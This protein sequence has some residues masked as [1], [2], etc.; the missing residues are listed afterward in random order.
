MIPFYWDFLLCCHYTKQRS[1][2]L[3]K[4]N[5][6]S[7]QFINIVVNLLDALKTSFSHRSLQARSV[8]RKDSMSDA[9]VAR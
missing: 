6:F 2:F 1:R 4:S 5:I 3:I 7:F 8:G 9:A